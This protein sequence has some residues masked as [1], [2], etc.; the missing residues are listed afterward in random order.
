MVVESTKTAHCAATKGVLCYLQDAQEIGTKIV[1]VISVP[2]IQ[3]GNFPGLS[4]HG[5]SDWAER[6][7]TRSP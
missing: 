4:A 1:D 2:R 5:D 7:K 6:I 3:N